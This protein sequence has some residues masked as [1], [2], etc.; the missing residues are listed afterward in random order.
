MAREGDVL[1]RAGQQLDEFIERGLHSLSDLSD[2]NKLMRG[3]QQT[4]RKAAATLGVSQETI[5][6][7]ERRAREDKWLFYTGFI[8]L[9][10]LFYFIDRWWR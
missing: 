8:V 2:Q 7:V 10:L 5:S 1:A 3:T 6:K 9:L 4:L